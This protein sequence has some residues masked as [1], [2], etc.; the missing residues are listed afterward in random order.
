MRITPRK[1]A[2]KF[3]PPRLCLIYE[4]NGEELFHEFPI[5]MEDL[6]KP[7]NRIYE[8]L[9]FEHPG[10]LEGIESN[11]IFNLIDKIKENSLK[12][13][14]VITSDPSK[15]PSSADKFRNILD[16]LGIDS[17]SSES[18]ENHLD[19]NAVEKSFQNESDSDF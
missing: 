13:A 6:K 2:M 10:Y 15:K 4:A 14:P 5:T 9:K 7:T 16:S 18:E 3:K 1:F 8:D 19:Y 11:Q 12:P 17:N